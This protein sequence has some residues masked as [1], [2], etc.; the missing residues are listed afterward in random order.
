MK[1]G[2]KLHQGKVSNVPSQLHDT[3]VKTLA[4]RPNFVALTSQVDGLRRVVSSLSLA[5]SRE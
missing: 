1:D 2:T 5:L 3:D 4:L